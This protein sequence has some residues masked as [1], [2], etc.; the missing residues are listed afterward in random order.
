M[1]DRRSAS[2]RPGIASGPWVAVVVLAAGLTLAACVDETHA[3]QVA[4]LGGETGGVSP[5]P[6]HRPGQP[7]LVCHGE[8]GPSSHTFVI[9]GTVYAKQGQSAPAAGVQVELEDFSGTFV[10]LNTNEAGNF[11]IPTGEW[12]PV[13]PVLVPQISMGQSVE[14]MQTHIARDGSCADCHTLNPGPTSPGPVFLNRASS[15]GPTGLSMEGGP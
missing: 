3:E 4:A 2:G 7:C 6:L 10:S 15:S 1:R 14:T 9:A 5:G 8:A 13:M 12:S 11:Y